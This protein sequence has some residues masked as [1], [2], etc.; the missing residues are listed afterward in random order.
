MTSSLR[1]A[2]I[3][4]AIGFLLILAVI[5]ITLSVYLL[6]LIPSMGRENEISQMSDVKERFTEYKLNIDSLWT[7]G[8]CT[9][10][11]GP[12]LTLGSGVDTG[13]LSFFPFFSPAKGGAVLALN[14]RAENI[15]IT[16]D[17]LF[18]VNSL[19]FTDGGVVPVSPAS[20]TL[21]VNTMPQHFY[22]NINESDLYN[23][24][25]V[26]I[27]GPS[28]DVWV[29]STPNY[30]YY[31][32]ANISLNA[33]RGGTI[34]SYWFTSNRTLISTDITVNTLSNNNLPLVNNL[35]VIRRISALKVYPVDLMSPVYGISTTFQNPQT[36]WISKSDSSICATYLIN[37]GY[38]PS[39]INTTYPMGSIEFRSNNLYYTPQTYYYQLGGV[40]LEQDNG[41][42]SEVPPSISLSMVNSI[43]I[44]NIGEILIQGGVM[45]TNMSGSGPI[46]VTSAVTGITAAPLLP[47]TNNTRWV[48]LTIK[49][50]NNNTAEMWNQTFKQL[51]NQGGLTS[52]SNGRA[53]NVTFLYITGDPTTYGVQLSLTQ[54]NVSADY[55]LQYTFGGF[56]RS[57]Q[58]VPG[59]PA[60][61]P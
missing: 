52:Y 30:N 26:L 19:G 2:G 55:V 25:G 34:E 17:S 49:A 28:W 38:T 44:V 27:D 8:Q 42:I 60:P 23:Q 5:T 39:G 50:A 43:P 37:Y 61:T 3:S 15:T 29:N 16:S 36:I 4:E 56:S 58:G 48:N 14:Q 57:W 21:Y 13:I 10:A 51:A 40:F 20:N 22:I 41:S 7:S 31:T 59:F 47:G 9:T 46:T 54:V 11:F 33:T 6:Y 32:Q 35:V 1:G 53:G 18:L 45:T 24:S 12:A